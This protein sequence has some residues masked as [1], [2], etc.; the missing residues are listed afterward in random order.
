MPNGNTSISLGTIGTVLEVTG[1][2][3][4]VW[5]YVNPVSTSGVL[6]QGDTARNNTIFKARKYAADYPGFAG[7]DLVPGAP[8]EVYP[9]AVDGT[10]ASPGSAGICDAFPNPFTGAVQ[11]ETSGAPYARLA[12][13]DT[14]GRRVSLLADG[15]QREGIRQFRWDGKDASYGAL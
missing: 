7:K 2:G 14:R 8:I 4:V 9:V 3:E 6:T 11:I 15:V 12:V 1:N 10:P 5:Q 13:Y